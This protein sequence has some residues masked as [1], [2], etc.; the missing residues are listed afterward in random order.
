MNPIHLLRMRRWLR[1]PQSLRRLYLILAV[2]ALCIA[3]W[4]IDRAGLWPDW[5]TAGRVPRG[6]GRLPS[7]H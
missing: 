5:A 7:L 3:I 1:H 6:P 2:V 4:G